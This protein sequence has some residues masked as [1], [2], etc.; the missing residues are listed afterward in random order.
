MERIPSGGR[1]ALLAGLVVSLAP[2]GL[3]AVAAQSSA[4]PRQVF[5]GFENVPGIP[6][7]ALVRRHGGV[8]RFAFPSVG[9]LAIDIE[10]DRIA[11]L[12]REVGVAYVE[13][14]PVREPL[15]LSTAELTPSLEN[16]LYGLVTTRAVDAHAADN[17]EEAH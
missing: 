10:A 5:V 16:G 11:A 12:A 4:P 6:E 9:A 1:K 7:H 14:D 2:V 8:V 15:G 17:W 13:E 3:T